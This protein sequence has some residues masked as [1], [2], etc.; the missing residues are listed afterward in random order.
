MALRKITESQIA[1]AAKNAAYV[2]I[3]QKE[4]QEGATGDIESI[5]RVSLLKVAQKIEELLKL[6]ENYITTEKMEELLP[7][8]VEKV[9][10]CEEGIRVTFGDGRE[11]IIAID[12]LAYTAPDIYGVEV[13]FENN[14]IKRIG[15]AE[16]LSP[17]ADFDN[18]PA[19]HRSRCIVGYDGTVYKY[20]GQRGY[21]ET[22]YYTPENQSSLLSRVRVN[23]CVE[24]PP[25]WAKVVPLAIEP[26]ADG[27]FSVRKARYYISCVPHEGFTLP[28]CFRASA[29]GK[30]RP[31]YFSAYPSCR[32]DSNKADYE[33]IIGT[34][35]KAEIDASSDKLAS[36]V[37]GAEIM[38]DRHFTGTETDPY[39]NFWKM[40]PP[41][42]W[43]IYS[44]DAFNVTRLLFLIEYASFNAVGEI[45]TGNNAGALLNGTGSTS[46]L[47]NASGAASDGCVSYRGEENLW[48]GSFFA[49]GDSAQELE[50]G[51]IMFFASETDNPFLPAVCG[52]DAYIAR[53]IGCTCNGTGGNY[54]LHGGTDCGLYSVTQS[55]STYT[56]RFMYTGI[57]RTEYK[58]KVYRNITVPTS[59]WLPDDTDA[60]FPYSATIPITDTGDDCFGNIIFNA[61]DAN[62]GYYSPCL[63]TTAAGIKIFSR[64]IP[65]NDIVIPAI[66]IESGIEVIT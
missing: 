24:Q 15:A 37:G 25:I 49:T 19:W 27:R 42:G 11:E 45:G 48:G 13:D 41:S 21:T 65:E 8:T 59:D 64:V 56:V 4:T 12:S 10:P 2:L 18:I 36:I 6:P 30:V 34:D 32:Y 62:S 55:D 46:D 20:Y 3:T 9:E 44:M 22:G 63:E 54:M 7:D 16:G 26:H 17:G 40:L 28:S 33:S 43:E 50:T 52:D 61:A 35:S 31:A 38:S 1:E 58:V 66:R 29:D 47:G 57:N 51:Y 60:A 23:V 39:K 53:T 14:I 5:R